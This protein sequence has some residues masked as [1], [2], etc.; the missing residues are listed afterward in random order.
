M[1]VVLKVQF[2]KIVPTIR[3]WYRVDQ[4]TDILSVVLSSKS[5]TLRTTRDGP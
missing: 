4:S 5:V 2:I 1:H 3:S